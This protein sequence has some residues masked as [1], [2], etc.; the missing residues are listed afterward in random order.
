MALNIF[1][2]ENKSKNPLVGRSGADVTMVPAAPSLGRSVLVAPHVTEKAARLESVGQYVFRVHPAANQIQIRQA[3]ETAYQVKV[4]GVQV[5]KIPAKTR[6]LGKHVGLK[7]GYKKAI[8]S[9]RPGDKIQ[10]IA[11]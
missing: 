3:V 9:L 6:R 1:K 2:K 8:V 10:L 11:K 5:V 7:A 4:A